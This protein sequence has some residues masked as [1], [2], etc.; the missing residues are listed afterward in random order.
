MPLRSVF[1]AAALAAT[2]S[3][4]LGIRAQQPPPTAVN[5]LSMQA[6]SLDPADVTALTGEIS[7]RSERLKPLFARVT[8]DTWVQKGAPQVYVA[9]WK[10]LGQQNTSIQVD[11]ADAGQHTDAMPAMMSALFRIHRF[12]T[13][14][15]G[16]IPAIRRYQDGSLADQIEAAF[17]GDQRA[18]EKLQ[19]YVLDLA[20]EKER[21]LDLENSEAQRCRAQLAGQPVGRPAT[22]KSNGKSK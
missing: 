10:S 7:Q 13:D 12:D 17:A 16:M 19:Q 18:V 11:M 4:W 1:R 5:R 6:L 3:C 8:P 9:Q 15:E 22:K 21:L 14:L 2:V 20:N